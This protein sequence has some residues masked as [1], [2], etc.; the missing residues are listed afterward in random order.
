MEVGVGWWGCGGGGEGG[1][2]GVVEM[3]TCLQTE[4]AT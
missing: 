1:G 2:V 4:T 3:M